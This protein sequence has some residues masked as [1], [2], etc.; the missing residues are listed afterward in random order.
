MAKLL[1]YG[2]AAIAA[3]LAIVLVA[4]RLLLPSVADKKDEI[5][6]LLVRESGYT[7][8]IEQVEGYWDY[9]YPG[10]RMR[11]IAV[12]DDS[13][14]RPAVRMTELR[15]SLK[16]LPLFVGRLDIHS[17][18]LVQPSFA[19]ERLED[20][21][22]Q[23]TGFGASEQADPAQTEMFLAWLFRQRRV[24][25]QEGE[26]QWLDRREPSRRLRF[27]HVNLQLRNSGDRH[28][29]EAS[30]E[31]PA[32][33][34]NGCSLAADINGNPFLGEGLQG[35][36]YVRARDVDV[37]RLPLALREHLPEQLR[38]TYSVELWSTWKDSRPVSV[39]GELA[40]ADL[41]LPFTGLR[42]P[43]SV[44]QA[45]TKLHWQGSADEFEMRL[46]NLRLALHGAPWSAGK[47]QFTRK[48]DATSLSIGRVELA[49]I[50]AFVAA[51]RMDP[52]PGELPYEK[53]APLWSGLG[54]AGTIKNLR[55]EVNG[56]LDAPEDY[57]LSADVEG[58][59]TAAYK[60]WPGV[61]GVSGRLRL[62]RDDGTLK[63]DMRNGALT[64]P[65]VF[66]A[67]LPI[68]RAA[69][70]LRWGY[71]VDQWVI[72]AESLSLENEDI[73]ASGRM[74]FRLPDDAAR[75]PYLALNLEF[76]D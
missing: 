63:L 61:R 10:L 65:A 15:F 56:A 1:W 39:N 55:V 66:R 8:R 24:V 59:A 14:Q 58:L 31:L 74:L 42:A 46:D 64:L 71:E 45:A 27:M 18:V 57:T 21:R 41:R 48:S 76:H 44:K 6:A 38:G 32:G 70:E 9:L 28:R 35:D 29:L 12:S 72:T 23:I 36:L 67:P 75:S 43:L 16:I 53:L 19:L 33:M 68:A 60:E 4:A 25:M 62:T 3:L 73:K 11:G 26:L 54:P 69:V 20:G 17:A 40:V 7:V 52:A 22:F 13:G 34:C 51:L 37:E 30:A 50:T 2:A 49:D 5:E 47:L